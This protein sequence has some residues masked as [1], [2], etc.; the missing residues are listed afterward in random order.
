[1][2]KLVSVVIPSYNRANYIGAT[3][4]SVLGQTYRNIEIIVI[5]DGS[6][7]NTED[8]VSKYLPK[9]KYIKQKNSERGASRNHGLRLAK[10]EFISFLDSDDLWLPN[11]IETDLEFFSNNSSIGVIYTDAVQIDAQSYEIKL[12]KAERV[13]GKITERLLA[14]NFV[15][16]ATHLI[17]TQLIR[18][19]GG[20]L[21]ER[22][23]S[24]S[25]D[26]EMWVR[27]STI[28]EFAYL[29]KVTAKIRTHSANT[30]SDADGMNRSMSY[31]LK[32]MT[33]SDYLTDKQKQLLSKT[34][35]YISLIN[36]IN[37][38]TARKKKNV[39]SSLKRAFTNDPKIIFDSRFGYTI[40][41]LIYGSRYSK[42]D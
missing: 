2:D 12:L 28:T 36:A 21:E 4:E 37:Y 42:T 13:K 9:V 27:L 40:W 38:C 22:E 35:A 41:R 33:E 19:I 7:D 20:F 5:D 34:R 26:W 1:M 31:A 25:E 11:K 23:L 30:M 17:R 3:I 16:M 10:G 8:V 39:I 32:I 14:N 29:P 24:G 6:T 18:N 15:L